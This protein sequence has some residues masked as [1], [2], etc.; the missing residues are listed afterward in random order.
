MTPAEFELAHEQRIQSLASAYASQ[1]SRAARKAANKAGIERRKLARLMARRNRPPLPVV[2]KP[3]RI[4]TAI[5]LRR[6]EYFRRLWL[7]RRLAKNKH[8]DGW[9]SWKA[10]VRSDGKVFR[11]ISA[12]ARACNGRSRT[13]IARAL[14]IGCMAY[15]YHWTSLRGDSQRSAAA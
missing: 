3:T 14:E 5:C 9:S 1:H 6:R 11:S 8:P 7:K 13:T 15:G 10:I 4:P 12:A 2:E